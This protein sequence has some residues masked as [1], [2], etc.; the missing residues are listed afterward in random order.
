[1]LVGWL[2]V[3]TDLFIAT[4]VVAGAVAGF[5]AVVRASFVVVVV[6]VVVVDREAGVWEQGVGTIVTDQC[7][8]GMYP[9]FGVYIFTNGMGNRGRL[10]EWL[11]MC[12]CMFPGDPE[13]NCL[14]GQTFYLI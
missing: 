7:S 1:M 12:F 9:I 11:S 5:G 13:F 4:V 2:W 6:V 3:V 10:A 8:C 14:H